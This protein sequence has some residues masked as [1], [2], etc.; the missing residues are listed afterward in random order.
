MPNP[1]RCCYFVEF[2]HKSLEKKT[3]CGMVCGKRH[4]LL[5]YG[6]FCGNFADLCKISG[7]ID[8]LSKI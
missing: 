4:F 6:L 7:I 2:P 8:S 3:V 5:I 1:S